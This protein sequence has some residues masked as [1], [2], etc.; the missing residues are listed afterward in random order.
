MGTVPGE[1][2]LGEKVV[3]NYVVPFLASNTAR[4]GIFISFFCLWGF[5][6]YG[7]SQ[8]G[9]GLDPKYLAEKGT[10][11]YYF[12]DVR[13]AYFGFFPSE[14]SAY[15]NDWHDP[16]IQKAY[17]ETYDKVLAVTNNFKGSEMW[18]DNF[19]EWA[20]DDCVVGPPLVQKCGR[21]TFPP[22]AVNSDGFF[23][24]GK[25]EFYTC[26]NHWN[27]ETLVTSSP[28]FYELS[29]GGKGNDKIV[30]PTQYCQITFFSENMFSEDTD[31]FVN[32]I[33]AVRD[34]ME[35]AKDEDSIDL[36]PSGDIFSFWEQY[37]NLY[38]HLINNLAIATMCTFAIG[39]IAIMVATVKNC[40]TLGWSTLGLYFLKAMQGSAIMTFAIA[41][42]I[43]T[44]LGFM[45]LAG[46]RMS[47]IPALTVI[48]CMGI[49][50]DLTALITLFF[51]QNTGNRDERI[52][53][54]LEKVFVPTL[55]SMTSTIVGCMALGFS[56]VHMFVLYFFVMYVMVAII[57]TLNGLILLPVLLTMFGPTAME[58]GRSNPLGK[59][60][61][62]SAQGL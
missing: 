42:T 8:M 29:N 56:V 19:L 40:S 33:D 58:T 21:E 34:I 52:K 60:R 55:D 62:L 50:V 22:C 32:M 26:L 28:G 48:A 16:A 43:Y 36:F 47:A 41:S 14:I 51:C 38:R 57:G 2:S 15:E 54:A 45:G 49:C 27:V 9:M 18:L 10:Q 25:E 17:L 5:S 59:K 35:T 4:V 20:S 7:I 1:S 24:A 13:G 44:L 39:T 11:A 31:N 30:A 61:S 53:D 37:R 12:Y 23:D 3:K 46:I 6:A